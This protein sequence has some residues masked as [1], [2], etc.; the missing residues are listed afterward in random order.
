MLFEAKANDKKMKV[1]V[2]KLLKIEEAKSTLHISV[3]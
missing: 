2:F 1:K 3:K